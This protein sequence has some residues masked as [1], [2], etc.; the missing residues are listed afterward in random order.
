MMID[1][2]RISVILQSLESTDEQFKASINKIMK[3]GLEIANNSEDF[4]DEMACY[5]DFICHVYV[6]DLDFNLW[7]H[8]EHKRLSFNTNYYEEHSND[9]RIVH[10]ILKKD[11]LKKI[12]HRKMSASEAYMKGFI[13]IEGNIADAMMI[14]NMLQYFFKLL[15]RVVLN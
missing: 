5:D 1:S 7:I 2:N 8:H 14:K 11:I 6:K 15:A 4:I 10:F 3:I 12:I 9:I 13:D